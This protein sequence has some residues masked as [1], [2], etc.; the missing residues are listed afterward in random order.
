MARPK[1]GEHGTDLAP[2]I[3]HVQIT[4]LGEAGYGIR[5]AIPVKIKR[6]EAGNFEASFRE[7]NIAISGVDSDDAYQALVAEI[8][9]T[10]DVLVQEPTLGPDAAEQLRILRTHI[11]RT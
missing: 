5:R 10:F 6:I 11:V 9:D 7:A 4:D 8:L 3:E 2:A 1:G